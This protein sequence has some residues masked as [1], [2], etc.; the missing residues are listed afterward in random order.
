MAAT[1]ITWRTHKH[2]TAGTFRAVVYSFGYQ[3]PQ[4]TLKEGT[5]PTRERATGFARRWVR[6]LKAQ[7]RKES[8]P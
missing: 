2:L 5:F 3:Q 6:Y 4:V 8:S 1:V 7:Q